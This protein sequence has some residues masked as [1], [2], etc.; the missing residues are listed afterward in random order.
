MCEGGRSILSSCSNS[1]APLGLSL[2]SG[3]PWSDTVVRNQMSSA[4]TGTV[5]WSL[6]VAVVFEAGG[7]VLTSAMGL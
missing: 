5:S 6:R 1:F 4:V 2:G 7:V 3:R